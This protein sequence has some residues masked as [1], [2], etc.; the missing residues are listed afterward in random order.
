MT[1]QKKS[2]ASNVVREQDVKKRN[3]I[4]NQYVKDKTPKFSIVKNTIKAY[5]IGGIICVIGQAFTNYYV[6][7]M[8]RKTRVTVL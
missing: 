8:D 7:K 2:S 1:D 4:Y 6:S 5:L 3:E